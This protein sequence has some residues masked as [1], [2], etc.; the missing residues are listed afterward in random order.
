MRAQSAP[1]SAPVTGSAS[2]GFPQLLSSLAANQRFP[3]PPLW[4][5]LLLGPE[6]RETL[7]FTGKWKLSELHALGIFMEA[8]TQL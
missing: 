4:T 5:Q 3:H 2:P 1:T 6:L 7:L 8:S